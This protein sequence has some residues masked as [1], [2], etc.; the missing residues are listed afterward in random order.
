MKKIILAVAVAAVATMAF[1]G[2]A[3][4][5]VARYQEV[6][7]LQVTSMFNGATYV[8]DYVLTDSNP[9][10]DGSFS[11]TG[12]PTSVVPDEASTE[13]SAVRTSPSAGCTRTATCPTPATPGATPAR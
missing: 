4:A 2:S 12:V 3:S 8:H 9:C 11:G 13:R 5:G 7:G 6:T 1:V 10:G